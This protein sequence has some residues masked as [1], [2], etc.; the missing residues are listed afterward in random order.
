[1]FDPYFNPVDISAGV[2]VIYTAQSLYS[3]YDSVRND[4][5]KEDDSGTE[6]EKSE[7]LES[8]THNNDRS[9]N[10]SFVMSEGDKNERII[11]TDSEMDSNNLG[12]I[13]EHSKGNGS[14]LCNGNR[15]LNSK[16][17]LVCHKCCASHPECSCSYNTGRARPDHNISNT[18]PS[19]PSSHTSDSSGYVTQNETMSVVSCTSP[20][21]KPAIFKKNQAGYVQENATEVVRLQHLTPSSQSSEENMNGQSS[22]SYL[23]ECTESDVGQKL[24]MSFATTEYVFSSALHYDHGIESIK[25]VI[26]SE[27]S[28]EN[29]TDIH[30]DDHDLKPF[31][32]DILYECSLSIN[33]SHFDPIDSYI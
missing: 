33:P 17:P 5:K 3:V 28:A 18:V 10:I 13:R 9:S 22:K 12:Y 4:V 25:Q 1:M 30:E 8:V 20:L 15:I 27:N 32:D 7:I 16:Q 24:T 26:S 31:S 11:Q 29:E 19:M 23:K 21:F 14:L 2:K 6:D